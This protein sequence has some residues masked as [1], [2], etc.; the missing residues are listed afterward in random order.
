MLGKH[1]LQE[2]I[3]ADFIE[4]QDQAELFQREM[5]TGRVRRSR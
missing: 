5:C 4:G 3:A 2:A 1:E